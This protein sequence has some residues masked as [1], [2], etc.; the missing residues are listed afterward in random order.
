[1]RA[2]AGEAR[3]FA[4]RGNEW[5]AC[6]GIA[7]VLKI[8]GG[9]DDRFRK[10]KAMAER[11]VPVRELHL[12]GS[13][14]N[15]PKPVPARFY[16]GFTFRA[17]GEVAG[18]GDGREC[19]DGFPDALF[20]LPRYELEG[21]GA[22]AL[23][24]VNELT[25]GKVTRAVTDRMFEA[26][27]AYSDRLVGPFGLER[28][29][30]GADP[31]PARLCGTRFPAWRSGVESVLRRVRSGQVRKVVLARTLDVQGERV[32]DP[33]DVVDR[34]WHVGDESHIFLIEPK[35]GVALVG[36][37]P[38]TVAAVRRESF[39]AT[40]VAG[41]VGRGRTADEDASLGRTLLASAKDRGEQRMVVRD[42]VARLRSL[43]REVDFDPEP[44]VLRL[45]NL[46]HLETRIR[47]RVPRG[48]GVLDLLGSLHPTPAVCGVPRQAAEAALEAE[49]PFYRGWYAGP[50]GWFDTAGNG[51][52]VPAL[53]TGVTNSG[54][55][56]LFAG[57]GIVAGSDADSEWR[58]TSLK[59]TPMLRA[60]AAGGLDLP[61]T[62]SEAGF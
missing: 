1:M 36:A 2:A 22:G 57:A 58:E 52:F 45:A 61:S 34:L 43:C 31:A 9:E 62:A 37:A 26:A 15:G 38:E 19:W 17:A 11:L 48:T 3:G 59:F 30:S 6:A 41:S 33:V 40:A 51:S 46:Q 50:V 35:A 24:K 18:S 42:M 32:V 54:G 53:R 27:K 49:E 39:H 55:W 7:A 25:E 5:V 56:R 12:A 47:A 28:A 23:L 21:D 14:S 20:H 4:A 29:G 10:A 13:G 8:E 60:L 16:G 44:H